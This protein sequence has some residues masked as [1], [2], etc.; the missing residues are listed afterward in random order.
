M[1]KLSRR[2][3]CSLQTGS[4]GHRARARRAGRTLRRTDLRVTTQVFLARVL[5]LQGRSDQAVRTAEMSVEEAQ[6]TGH[7]PSLCYS[8]ALACPIAMWV[9]NLTTAARYTGMLVESS[10]KHDLPRWSTYGSR[11]Q[12]A[13][14]LMGGNVVAGLQLL[15]ASLDEIA[16]SDLSFRSFTSLSQL[17]E[18]LV[19]AGRMAE[20]HCL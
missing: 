18:V 10:R 16:Q 20:G 19:H 17:V 11:F 14:V 5:W 12:T 3:R 4:D 2:C 8:L 6:A 13:V 1:E 7:A 15:D 9:G